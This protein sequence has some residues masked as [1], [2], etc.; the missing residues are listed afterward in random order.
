M[1]FY[2]PDAG[3]IN[4][5]A[6]GLRKPGSRLAGQLKP[7]DEL[8][9]STAAGKGS[10]DI[11]TG[12]SC[13]RA[14]ADWQGDLNLLALYW[15]MLECAW[16]ASS[17]EGSNAD[18]YRL[19]INLLRSEPQTS[20]RMS[21]ASVYCIRFLNLHGML[22]D[23]HHDEETDERLETDCLCRPSFEG[24]LD[25]KRAEASPVL[26]HGMLRIEADRLARWRALLRRPL[27]EYGELDCDATDAALL[28]AFTRNHVA[29]MSD[30]AVRS[31]EFLQRQWKLVGLR[32]LIR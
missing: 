4:T 1:R 10:T 13:S 11:L 6:R 20:Q 19:L 15:F 26:Q 25:A 16:L 31:A 8:R 7:A 30:S 21:L 18:G 23:L 9:I 2:T 24:L 17:D 28:V 27:L 3:G 29:S 22:P 32:E 14:H 5:I 12:V